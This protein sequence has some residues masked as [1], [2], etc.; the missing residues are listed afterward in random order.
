MALRAEQAYVNYKPN[1]WAQR[2]YDAYQLSNAAT[3]WEGET[4]TAV[5]L[6]AI[7]NSGQNFTTTMNCLGFDNGLIDFRLWLNSNNQLLT[8]RNAYGMFYASNGDFNKIGCAGSGCVTG[9]GC[10][11]RYETGTE[12][13]A[14]HAVQAK[15]HFALD[16]YNPTDTVH[17]AKVLHAEATHNAGEPLHPTDCQN[18]CQCDSN[19][20]ADL[21][22]INCNQFWRVGGTTSTIH[23]VKVYGQDRFREL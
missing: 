18:G 21:F 19:L 7:A 3:M 23:K 20:M 13:R 17:L 2:I 16:V 9:Y 8:N 14:N 11:Q 4:A 5:V 10:L 12:I 1:D 22:N 15:D 6:L